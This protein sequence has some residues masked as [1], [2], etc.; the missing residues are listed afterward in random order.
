VHNNCCSIDN[1][2]YYHIF[3]I[4]IAYIHMQ[5]VSYILFSCLPF[6]SA[7]SFYCRSQIEITIFANSASPYN[8]VLKLCTTAKHLV[9]NHFLSIIINIILAKETYGRI[10]SKD[11]KRLAFKI[12]IAFR[13]WKEKRIIKATNETKKNV[14]KRKEK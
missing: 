9:A 2:V 10:L 3:N 8:M 4:S 12:Y 6:R 13:F 7:K 11:L 14:G 5:T 1:T